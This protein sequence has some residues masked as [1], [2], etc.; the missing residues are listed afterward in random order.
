MRFLILK[1][2]NTWV[3][4]VPTKIVAVGRNYRAHAQ[5]M[6]SAV[7]EIPTFFLKP[8]SSLIGDTGVVVLPAASQRVDHEVELAVV[9]K[10]R[11]RKVSAPEALRFILGY[12]VFI[13]VTA[14]DLQAEA[15]KKGLSWAISKGFDTFAPIGPNIV[16]KEE[17]DPRDLDI[18]LKVN[19]I[20]RQH[21]TTRDMLFSVNE[22][23]SHISNIMTLEPMDVVATGTPEGIG[24]MVDGDVVEAG[25]EGIGVLTVTV[26]RDR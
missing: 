17:I 4:L 5:E 8:P 21:G 6:G 12:T 7:P 18:W 23:I 3:D 2:E 11:C 24:P 10:D 19:G 14:R 13:D 15:K 16:S 25:I 22:L 26:Q 1:F 20:Y 9:M